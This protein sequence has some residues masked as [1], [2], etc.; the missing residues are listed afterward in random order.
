MARP[1]AWFTVRIHSSSGRVG[2]TATDVAAAAAAAAAPVEDDAV[3][4]AVA[5]LAVEVAESAL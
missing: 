5:A 2:D 1:I 4:A 3:A